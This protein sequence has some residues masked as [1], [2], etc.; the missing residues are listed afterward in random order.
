[1]LRSLCDNDDMKLHLLYA[2]IFRLSHSLY[3]VHFNMLTFYLFTQH[4][5]IS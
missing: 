2:Y 1:M 4:A 3:V 5:R